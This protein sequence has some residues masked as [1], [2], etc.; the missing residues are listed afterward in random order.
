AVGTD[1]PH[2]SSETDDRCGCRQE[3]RC[4]VYQCFG[5]RIRCAERADNH[6][7][8]DFQRID[9]EGH[10]TQADDNE[11]ADYDAQ[12][13]V[14]QRLQRNRA[15]LR[16][17]LNDFGAHDGSLSSPSIIC[18]MPSTVASARST[19]PTMAPARMTAMRS[20]SANNS[21]ISAETRRTA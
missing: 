16:P 11:G 9:A 15:L 3:D 19:M 1:I 8:I 4:G 5:N 18:P 6:R 2:A 17:R 10:E 13:A 7:A 21:S 20:L 14:Q 12:R